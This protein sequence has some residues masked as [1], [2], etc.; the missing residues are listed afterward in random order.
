[1]GVFTPWELAKTTN[2]TLF[3]TS[4]EPVVRC[5]PA[6]PL[7]VEVSTAITFL[8]WHRTSP[9]DAFVSTKNRLHI[10][11]VLWQP[12]HGKS[13]P[14]SKYHARGRPWTLKRGR[15]AISFPWYLLKLLL[16]VSRPPPKKSPQNSLCLDMDKLH[17]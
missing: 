6:H 7:P 13:D 12:V 8:P 10:L 4:G 11:L 1:M 3:F 5:L 15:K 9:L 17:T 14:N 16:K 2:Q